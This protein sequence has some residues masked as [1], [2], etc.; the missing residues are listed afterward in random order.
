M[1]Q[2]K[3]DRE[4]VISNLNDLI[5][6][7]QEY[8]AEIGQT[9]P[10]GIERILGDAIALLKEREP[11]EPICWANVDWPIYKC[12]KCGVILEFNQSYCHECGLAVKWE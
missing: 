11:V 8:L 5:Y 7:E 4:K 10:S 2:Q 1:T 6:R 12:G 3:L 9:E